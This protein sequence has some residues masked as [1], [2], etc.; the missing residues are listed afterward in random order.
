MTRFSISL[1]TFSCM[2]R[3]SGSP[4]NSR[5]SA[6]VQSKS[7]VIF[8][9]RKPLA[10]GSTRLAPDQSE[11]G[12]SNRPASSRGR[13]AIVLVAALPGAEPSGRAATMDR[14]RPIGAFLRDLMQGRRITGQDI[15]N[16]LESDAVGAGPDLALGLARNRFDGRR[17]REGGVVRNDRR[18]AAPV[19]QGA[20]RGEDDKR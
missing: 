6:G 12:W 7:N 10:A 18:R 4:K 14:R 5:A 17:R 2:G 20:A 16:A 19:R 8:I 3:T 11:L 9:V 13:P 1:I 15:G